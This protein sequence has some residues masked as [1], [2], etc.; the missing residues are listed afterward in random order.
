LCGSGEGDPSRSRYK[1]AILSRWLR[2]TFRLSPKERLDLISELWDSLSEEEVKLTP[3]QAREL[4]R[5]VATF[6]DDAKTAIPWERIDAEL[7][8]QPR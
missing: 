7:I 5:R 8:K 3:A 4:D 6:D 1:Q 2:S